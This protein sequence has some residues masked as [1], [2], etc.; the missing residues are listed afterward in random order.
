MRTAHRAVVIIRVLLLHTNVG[1][2]SRLLLSTVSIA[3]SH[4]EFLVINMLLARI[5]MD[6]IK[7][8]IISSPYSNHH[9]GLRVQLKATDSSGMDGG[10]GP[11]HWGIA[12]FAAQQQFPSKSHQGLAAASFQRQYLTCCST[13]HVTTSQPASA[14]GKSSYSKPPC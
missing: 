14:T 2:L 3:Y 9:L 11:H 12:A 10:I 5:V 7:L 4:T 8:L 13:V 6:R 1:I